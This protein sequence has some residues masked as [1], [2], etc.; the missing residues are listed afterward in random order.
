MRM[1]SRSQRTRVASVVASLAATLPLLA[2]S[3]A[4]AATDAEQAEALI[5]EGVKLRASDNTA[6]ALPLFEQAYQISRSP[7]AAA[8]LGL[9]ELELGYWVEAERYLSEAIASAD[10][11]W[12]VKNKGTLKK[13][14]E[15][16]RANIGE[17][18]VTASPV[19]A[20]VSVN[21]KVVDRVLV[22]APM[23]LGKGL[24]D[25]EVRAPGYETARETLIVSGGKREQRT[26][27]LV[28]EPPKPVASEIRAGAVA[29]TRSSGPD[30]AVTLTTTPPSASGGEHKSLRLAA[31]ISAGAAVGALV[32]GGV[33]ALAAAGKSYDFNN[34][35]SVANGVTYRDCGTKDLNPAFTSLKA[36][37]D[38][39]FTLSLVGFI[40]A[41][42][43]VATSSVLFV[44]SSGGAA[45][46]G[47]AMRTL[48]CVPDPVGRGLGCTLRF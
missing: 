26:Y 29:S 27:T 47:G 22:G 33:E 15:T 42:A 28:R 48:A 23:R 32:F 9:C 19:S 44:M 1:S 4:R 21:H 39:A 11:P 41:G 25:V 7:R 18:V 36:D 37:Y 14:L 3:P 34:H 31:W 12:V 45:E 5:R 2:S 43:L 35:T 13:P 30:A 40:A 17:L 24:V 10:N 20:E 46:R 16:A 38:Q 6:R 8:Q